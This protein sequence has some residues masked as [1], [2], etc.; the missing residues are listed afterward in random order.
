MG[1]SYY[2][3]STADDISLFVQLVDPSGEGAPGKTPEVA[4]RRVR[5]THG[6][7]LDLYYWSGSTWQNTPAWLPMSELDAINCPGLYVY[8][9][10][11]SLVGSEWVYLAYFRNTA[12]PKGFAVEEHIV[13]DELYIPTPSPVVPVLPGDTVMGKL[14][15]MEDPLRPVALANADAVWDEPLGQH[16]LPGST[17]EALSR[18]TIPLVGSKMVTLRV[19]VTPSSAP[20]QGAQVDL[21]DPTNTFFI[22]RLYTDVVGE[23][24]L[25]INPGTYAVRLF[26]SGY[27]FT[28]P[29]T[30]VVVNDATITYLGTSLTII[31]PPSSPNLCAIYGTVR[32]AGGFAVSNA[33]VQAYAITPQIVN[34]TQEGSAVACTVTDANGYFRLELERK[35][36]VSF[37]IAEAGL[38][39]ERTVP[40]APTQ[41]LATWT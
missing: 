35:A 4:I 8:L 1:N 5:N 15:A 28:T 22:S 6:G 2:R 25:A 18:V 30:L 13:T 17:G 36:L 38:D 16:L 19:L 40:D 33:R 11:Q 12:D 21:Y 23:V 3:W 34:A 10:A 41:N 39:V 32:D 9:F 7:A 31:V 20:I 27:A 24:R 26:A 14:V 37:V 29:E